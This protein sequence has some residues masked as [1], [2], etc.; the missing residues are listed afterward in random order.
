MPMYSD[1]MSKVG[2]ILQRQRPG[3][4]EVKRQKPDNKNTSVPWC[5]TV[6]HQCKQDDE[7]I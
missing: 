4:G 1:N 2:G 3:G 6:Y 7:L 5:I